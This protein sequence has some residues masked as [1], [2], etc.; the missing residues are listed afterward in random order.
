VPGRRFGQHFL[1]RQSVLDRIAEAVCPEREPLVLEIGPGKGALT[2][3]LLGRADRVIAVEIDPA[4]I[5]RLTPR[6]AGESRLEVIAADV[7]AIDLSQWGPLV[8][9]GNLPYYITSP[10][11][12]KV[13]ALQGL[14][15]RAVFLVQREVADRITASPGSREYGY[16][17]VATQLF[18]R[19]ET[20]FTVPPAAFRP[21]PK[22][23]SAVIRLEIR[24]PD[25]RFGITDTPAFLKFASRCFRQK[26]KMLRNNLASEYLRERID[27]LPEAKLRAEQVPLER[28][29]AIYRSLN[30]S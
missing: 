8:V 22:V 29:A 30:G 18:A 11:L 27:A 6:F 7:L 16:L 10:I 14:L 28:L 2:A 25:D 24:S 21:P 23:D 9:A 12:E 15:R 1:I 13:L 19:A 20:L 4:M 5:A 26:R 3:P 17:S